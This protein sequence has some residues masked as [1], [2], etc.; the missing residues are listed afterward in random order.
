M[1]ESR[2]T[3][4][5]PDCNG[6]SSQSIGNGVTHAKSSDSVFKATTSGIRIRLF[7]VI[8][9]M[10]FQTPVAICSLLR[11]YHP[12][13]MQLLAAIADAT[14]KA[15]PDPKP[16]LIAILPSTTTNIPTAESRVANL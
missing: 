11:D 10:Y 8:I 12:G 9:F 13:S 3:R 16:Q 2:R 15:V 6:T 14:A 1:S 4:E 5:I 7:Y